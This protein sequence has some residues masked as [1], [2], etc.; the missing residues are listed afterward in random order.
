MNLMHIIGARPQFVKLAELSRQIRLRK[1]FKESILHTGQHWSE[2]M[3]GVFFRDLGIPKP[4]FDLEVHGLPHGA[5]TGRMM[6]GI[7]K[8]LL[9]YP[10]G[11][12]VVYGDTN[13]T[14]A[15]AVVA[16]KLRIPL[17]HVEAGLRSRDM[18]M[19]EEINRVVADRVSDLLFCPTVVS[20]DNL[21]R[22][23]FDPGKLVLTGDLMW[24]ALIHQSP[25]LP[26]GKRE[27]LPGDYILATIHRQE[28]L[29]NASRLSA[30]VASLGRLDPEIPVVLVAHPRTEQKI[31]ESGIRIPFRMLGPAAPLEMLRLV[32]DS[33]M[34]CT[35]SG[36][37]Q[38]EAYYFHKPCIT[39]REQTE[40]TE[41]VACGCNRVA[42]TDPESVWSAFLRLQEN[43]GSFD[44][45]FYGNGEAALKMAEA[46]ER[47]FPV[48]QS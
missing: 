28:N 10:P 33:R 2:E 23:G 8:V 31:R 6:E 4:D 11:L 35:D 41:L 36:G 5:M 7:E 25:R 17:V 37:L 38:K 32:R 21:I 48:S 40:W 42:G 24:D 15:G 9:E 39:L 14:L 22:E 18:G 1:G 47:F 26:V 29:E 34:V 3:S 30:W 27:D 43:K 20:V 19:P 44:Q 16:S 12:V 45:P 46:M 13:S